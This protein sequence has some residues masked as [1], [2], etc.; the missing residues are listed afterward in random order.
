MKLPRDQ[1]PKK[2]FSVRLSAK[3]IEAL[4]KEEIGDSYDDSNLSLELGEFSY[5]LRDAGVKFRKIRAKNLQ[6]LKEKFLRFI[7]ENK[8]KMD[9]KLAAYRDF[10]SNRISG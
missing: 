3:L 7:R 2:V 1:E 6:E 8:H 4:R 5:H 10:N 9:D